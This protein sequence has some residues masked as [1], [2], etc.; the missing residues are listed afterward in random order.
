MPP[1][2]YLCVTGK[3]DSS[4]KLDLCEFPKDYVIQ[5]RLLSDRL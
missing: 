2:Q 4:Q 5:S 3:H 1:T